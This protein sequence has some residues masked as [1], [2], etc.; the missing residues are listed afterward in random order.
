MR[1]APPAPPAVPRLAV[2]LAGCA[3]VALLSALSVAAPYPSLLSPYAL[4]V[5]VPYMIWGP[6]AA[7]AVHPILCLATSG[8]LL[9]GRL[10]RPWEA[11]LVLALAGPLSLFF[12][13][14]GIRPGLR[15]YGAGH[16]LGILGLNL[17][18]VTVLVLMTIS[19]F[20][21]PAFSRL[22]ALQILLWGWVAWSGLPWLRQ[23]L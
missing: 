23:L 15:H 12:T 7:F 14:W 11:A 21:R 6:A 3:L 9:S 17:A 2:L 4:T 13:V 10:R 19:S 18:A 16:T 1:G 5:V 20:R 22:A 8:G